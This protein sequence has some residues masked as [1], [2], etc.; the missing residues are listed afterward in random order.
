[1]FVIWI[2]IVVRRFLTC[3]NIEVLKKARRGVITTNELFFFAGKG[4]VWGRLFWVVI[5]P[6]KVAAGSMEGRGGR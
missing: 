3:D 1:M 2:G 6:K 4:R 5:A